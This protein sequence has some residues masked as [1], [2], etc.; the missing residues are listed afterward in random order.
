MDFFGIGAGIGARAERAAA[1]YLKRE[2][3][4]RIVARN[5][6]SGRYETD[7]IAYDKKS[8][9]IVFV[10]VKCRPAYAAV[11]GFYAAASAR[12]SACLKACAKAFLRENGASGRSFRFD[13]VEVN[14]DGNGNFVAINHF[15]NYM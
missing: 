7:I 15:E 3:G 13:A 1:R 9:C 6:R 4:L 8:G 14:H 5:Y 12:K 10:E 2:A 11:P